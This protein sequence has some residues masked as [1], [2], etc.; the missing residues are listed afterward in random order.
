M[1]ASM[2][3]I[4]YV[5]GALLLGQSLIGQPGQGPQER[6]ATRFSQGQR[7]SGG[8]VGPSRTSQGDESAGRKFQGVVSGQAVRYEV[9]LPAGY[10]QG[11]GKYPVIYWL[12]G[13]GGN[14]TTFKATGVPRR[15]YEEALQK[16]QI[17]PSLLVYV[18]GE[19]DSFYA[20]RFD[21]SRKVETAIMKD[22]LPFIET[23]YRVKLG[24][25][26]RA[27][28]GFSMGGF[29][30]MKLAMKYPDFWCVAVSVDGALL[31]WPELSRRH[32]KQ[33]AAL[34][35]NREADFEPNNPYALARA[36]A[37]AV[38]ASGIHLR[39]VVGKLQPQNEAFNSLLT[40]LGIPHEYE[41]TGCDHQT[42]CVLQT[43]SNKSYAFVGRCL[44]RN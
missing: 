6:P 8:E 38:K 19:V 44:G 17:P 32:G 7:P 10:E 9:D 24:R 2:E 16:G 39:L 41:L 3:R 5:F 23:N 30:A 21:G 15:F 22:L 43:E 37:D 18:D 35:Q 31:D 14:H 29:G 11:D 28:M 34:F 20:D 12:H 4:V 27:I 36:N 25:E 26:H 40:S 42:A 33:A 13:I 1:M